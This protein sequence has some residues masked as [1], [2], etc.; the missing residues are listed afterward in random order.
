MLEFFFL[1]SFLSG[2]NRFVRIGRVAGILEIQKSLL[3][4]AISSISVLAV[5]AKEKEGK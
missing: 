2:R 5:G 3:E 1:G 4:R